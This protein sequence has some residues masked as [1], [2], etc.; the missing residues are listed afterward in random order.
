MNHDE[1]IEEIERHILK[2][3]GEHS[4]WCVGTAKDARAPFFRRHL[5][6]DLGDGLIYREAFT[7]SAADQVI[8]HL[9]NACG[10]KP[11]PEAEGGSAAQKAEGSSALHD[12]LEPGKIVFVY[13]GGDA[14]NQPASGGLKPSQGL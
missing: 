10:L 5:A 3:G 8:D 12:A 1:I 7:T 11:A 2:F 14:K 9:V 13:R 6:A 4:E